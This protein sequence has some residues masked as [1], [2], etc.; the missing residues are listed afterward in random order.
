[1]VDCEP[2]G[3]LGRTK[4]SK[5]VPTDTLAYRLLVKLEKAMVLTERL[6]SCDPDNESEE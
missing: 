6:E 3:G 1:M 5:A 4:M 2:H